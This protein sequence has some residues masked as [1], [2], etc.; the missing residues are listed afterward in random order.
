MVSIEIHC[1][2][3]VWQHCF[4]AHCGCITKLGPWPSPLSAGRE[5][6]SASHS[7][8]FH[9]VMLGSFPV[10]VVIL[11]ASEIRT[12]H[13]IHRERLPQSN[14]APHPP[15]HHPLRKPSP[16]QITSRRLRPPSFAPNQGFL[17]YFGHPFPPATSSRHISSLLRP[18]SRHSASFFP[19]P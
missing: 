2:R 4:H 16:T 3:T 15:R 6:R 1:S 14:R 19:T 8:R 11:A 9:S 13:A 10:L 7:R 18:R 12:Q 17:T 5:R